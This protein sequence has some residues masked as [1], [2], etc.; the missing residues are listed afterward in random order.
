MDSIGDKNKGIK[1]NKLMMLVAILFFSMQL[2]GADFKPELYKEVSI[3]I[4]KATPEEYR[5]KKIWYQTRYEGF[6]KIFPNHV[7]DSGFKSEKY[8]WFRVI[9]EI[10]PVLTKKSDEYTKQL[11]TMK[12]ETTVKVYGKLKKLRHSPKKRQQDY[13]YLD[14]DKLEIITT[15]KDEKK[16]AK[17]KAKAEITPKKALK[18]KKN[19]RKIKLGGVVTEP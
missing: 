3:K 14:L 2:Y 15:P 1:M 18:K 9:P 19:R 4:L 13:F 16:I 6:R 12:N 5:N 7:I 10:I 11:T 17:Q 8:Y